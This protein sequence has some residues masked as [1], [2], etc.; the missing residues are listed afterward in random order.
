MNCDYTHGWIDW[1]APSSWAVALAKSLTAIIEGVETDF[2]RGNLAG[3]RRDSA[4]RL[5]WTLA[6]SLYNRY[7]KLLTWSFINSFGVMN[8]NIWAWL[9]CKSASLREW[10]ETPLLRPPTEVLLAWWVDPE[11]EVPSAKSR[12]MPRPILRGP[13]FSWASIKGSSTSESILLKLML[14]LENDTLHTHAKFFNNHLPINFKS[15][16]NNTQP[17]LPC[18]FAFHFPIG[19]VL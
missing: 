2:W 11:H 19:Q 5:A 16:Q 15:R 14:K 7:D 6:K 17:P 8:E 18:W 4:S 12:L 10:V 1:T 9:T 13:P 3:I